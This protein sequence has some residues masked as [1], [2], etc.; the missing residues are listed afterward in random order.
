M[1]YSL[2]IHVHLHPFMFPIVYYP[3]L[4]TP[5]I[6]SPSS[7]L[8]LF[9]LAVIGHEMPFKTPHLLL[10]VLVIRVFDHRLISSALDSA[11][12]NHSI[13]FAAIYHHRRKRGRNSREGEEERTEFIRTSW[14]DEEYQK[15]YKKV[16]TYSAPKSIECY[17]CMSHSYEMRFPILS[18][19]YIQ[20]LIF[21]HRCSEPG[22]HDNMP[23]VRCSSVCATLFEPDIEGGVFLGYKHIRG[24]IDKILRNGFNDTALRTHRFHQN[25]QCRT[26][27]RAQLFKGRPSDPPSIGDV[28][29]CSCYG[30][31]CNMGTISSTSSSLR[32][33]SLL[34]LLLRLLL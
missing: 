21:T 23:T 14:T 29:L 24:C 33:A 30:D 28:Q 27:S 8:L 6:F 34:I 4:L 22:N 7:D 16:R 2:V 18:R 3:H 20:P 9:F 12:S 11:P 1:T 19:T 17:S 26:L 31:K 10:F 32:F 5:I 15:L 25:N 13:H